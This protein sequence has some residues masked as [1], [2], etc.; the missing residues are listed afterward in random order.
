MANLYTKTGD[1]G[2]TGLVGGSRVSKASLRVEC[3]GTIDEANSMLG[4]AYA[5]SNIEY[6]KTSVKKIQGRL[7]SLGAELASDAEGFKKLD[8][9]IS[10]EDISFLE[11]V[12]DKC[13]ETTGVQTHFVIPGVDAASASLH[14]ARTIIRR[15]E[16]RIVELASTESVR[17]EVSKYVNR[18]SDAIYALARLQEETAK[19]EELK[20]KVTEIVKEKLKEAFASEQRPLTL[21]RAREIAARARCRALEIN[22]PVV[23]SV[24]DKGGELILL[25][26]M[27]GSLMGSL[28]VSYAKAYT[29]N[30]FKMSTDELGRAAQ[31]GGPLYGIANATPGK[32]VLFGGGFPYKCGGETVGGVGISGGTVEQDMDIARYALEE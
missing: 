13:T 27:D 26:R 23:I 9:V 12:V 17:E 6:V 7:F 1:K 30:A 5:A 14:V 24:V 4:T 21:D 32:I 29:A 11:G 15:A 16:R 25:E 31:P 20:S 3:Y 19:A 10:D 2:T 8:H 28:D 18:L 22:V